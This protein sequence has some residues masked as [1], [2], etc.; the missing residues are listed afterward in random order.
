MPGTRV[1]V[2]YLASEAGTLAAVLQALEESGLM[3][4]PRTTG[5]G[6]EW[7]ASIE[8]ALKEAQAFVFLITPRFQRSRWTQFEV[9]VAASRAAA[10]PGVRIVP[11]LTAGARWSDVPRALSGHRGIDANQLPANEVVK[12]IAR[13]IEG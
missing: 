6:E 7:Y 4:G 13:S 8:E 3:F 2:S 5:D 10:S 12:R 11:V 9:G 1:F